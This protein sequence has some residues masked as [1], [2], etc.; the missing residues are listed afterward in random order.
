M[1][2]NPVDIEEVYRKQMSPALIKGSLGRECWLEL[3]SE[4]KRV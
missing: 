1:F 3:I 4:L 2:L